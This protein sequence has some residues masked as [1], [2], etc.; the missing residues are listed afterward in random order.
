MAEP[1]KINTR[2]LNTCVVPLFTVLSAQPLDRFLP[3]WHDPA[4]SLDGWFF[5]GNSLVPR[6]AL[7]S[8]TS[9]Y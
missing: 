1:V 7:T 4:E 6:M 2:L 9:T 3:T 5:G 8:L